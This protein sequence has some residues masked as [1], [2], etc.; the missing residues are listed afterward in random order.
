MKSTILLPTKIK[1]GVQTGRDTYNGLLGYVIYHDGKVWRKEP[2]WEKWRH[3][4]VGDE[5]SIAKLNDSYTKCLEI[6]SEEYT[7]FQER[8]KIYYKTLDYYLRARRIDTLDAY[9]SG[10]NQSI[11]PE[12]IPREFENVLTEGFVLN[13]KAGD[14][15]G[16]WGNHRQAYTR[17]YDPRGFEIE[18]TINN[19]LYILDYASSIKGK[20]LEGKFI[21]GWDDKQLVLIPE[22]SPDFQEMKQYNDLLTQKLDK[23][24]LIVGGVYL[25][26]DRSRHVYL[27]KWPVYDGSGVQTPD[28]HWF[29]RED[30][31]S[32]W[33]DSTYHTS[34]IDDYKAYTGDVV[35]TQYYY[36]LLS[37]V[38]SFAPTTIRTYQYVKYTDADVSTLESVLKRYHQYEIVY[39]PS[40][41]SYKR[42]WIVTK[43]N[44]DYTGYAG[45]YGY[46]LKTAVLSRDKYGNKPITDEYKSLKDLFENNEIY[47]VE[48][49]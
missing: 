31:K 48:A 26:A 13:K 3:K 43:Y 22:G 29:L 25:K 44:Y 49:I 27:G 12:V 40:K 33:K 32:V 18:I 11:N 30:V 9:L 38:I 41:K 47:K 28:A 42:I 24:S 4:Y 35:D 39:I 2:S 15:K 46:K 37:K 16:S 1:V 19:L 8:Y 45:G 7:N 14:Y 6:A 10:L 34:N 17:V 20:G 5:E 21:Y 36:D 23:S